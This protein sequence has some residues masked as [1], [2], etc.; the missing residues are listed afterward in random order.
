LNGSVLQRIVRNGGLESAA[1]PE[2]STRRAL[3]DLQLAW[4]AL[5]HVFDT[6]GTL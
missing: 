2:N 6:I 4:A 5:D 3:P 1:P